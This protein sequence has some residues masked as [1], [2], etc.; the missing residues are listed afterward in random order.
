LLLGDVLPRTETEAKRREEFYSTEGEQTKR[1]A[2]AAPLTII[3]QKDIP[4]PGTPFSLFSK[5]LQESVS[6]TLSGRGRV[7]LYSARRGL[8]PVVSCIDCGHI[9]RCPNSGTPFS[10]IRTINAKGEEERWFVSRVSGRRTRAADTCDNC[11]SWRLRER[12]IG[13]QSVYDDCLERFPGQEIILFD[14]ITASTPKRA[15][16]LIEKFY[17]ARGT[18]LIGTQMALPYL[19]TR[20]VTLTAVTSLDA[21]RATP[22]WRSDETHLRLLLNLRELSEKEVIVQTRTTPDA[23]LKSAEAGTIESFYT[24]ELALREALR[25]PPFYT[26]IVLSWQG[27]K[28]AIEKTEIE[29]KNRTSAY[30]GT[31]YSDPLSTSTKILRHALFRLPAKSPERLELIT[32]L[33]HFPPYIKIEIDPNRIV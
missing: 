17:A 12:G 32:L 13:I 23:L 7:F 33:R 20:G 1:I 9:F 18:M 10:L 29:I 19:S 4:T 22:T 6:T 15:Q 21:A 14:H 26:F 8:A 27:T 30:E 25:Y 5:K 3:E 24:E 31:F 11:G 28:T 16:A 2:F